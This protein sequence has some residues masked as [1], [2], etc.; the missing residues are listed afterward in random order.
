[1][2][3]KRNVIIAVI[4]LLAIGFAGVATMLRINGHAT[5]GFDQEQFEADIIF[6]KSILDSEDVSD[7]T[8][9]ENGKKVYEILSNDKITIKEKNDIIN[10]LID[11]IEFD[12]KTNTLELYFN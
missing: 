12:D 6:T 3:K 9:I 2:T 8:I 4:L 1:M 10:T 11:R 5:V 7:T